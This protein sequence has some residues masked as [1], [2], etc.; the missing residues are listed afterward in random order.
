MRSIITLT[1]DFGT[2]DSYVASMKGAILKR[3]PD[4]TIIDLSHEIPHANIL[5]GAFFLASTIPFFPEATIHVAVVD[6]G[7]GTERKPLI[8]KIAGQ[9]IV[10]PD[11][12]LLTLLMEEYEL[13]KSNVISNPIFMHDKISPTFHGRDIFAPAA[14]TLASGVSPDEA[15]PSFTELVR[16]P[17]PIPEKDHKKIT[18]SIIHID[19][20]GNAITNI[21]SEHLESFSQPVVRVSSNTFNLIHRAYGQVA[22]GRPLALVGSTNRLEVSINKGHAADRLSIF[23][24]EKVT[25]EDAAS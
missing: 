2:S 12:G 6:P 15:G 5:D 7:V 17:L 18:G 16:I 21:T 11:N 9:T 25:V 1:T 4:V 23:V 19:H 3:N 8:S 22:D 13:E 14:A 24:G 10:H 20:F